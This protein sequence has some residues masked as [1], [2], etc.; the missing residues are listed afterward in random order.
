L[1]GFGIDG[2]LWRGVHERLRAF[3][4]VI[5][6][7]LPGHGRSTAYQG[8]VRYASEVVCLLDSLGV[9]RAHWVGHSI[10]GAIAVDAALT[11]PSRVASLV[12]VGSVLLRGSAPPNPEQIALATLASSGDLVGARRAW[13][14]REPFAPA[15]RRPDLCEALRAMID[16]YTGAHWLGTLRGVWQEPD[17]ASHLAAVRAPTLVAVGEDD[18]AAA[19]DAAVAY[20]EGIHGAEL[21]RL[22]G[23][24]HMLPMEDPVKTAALIAAFVD[25]RSTA[26][27]TEEK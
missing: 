3:H 1:H 24:S 26:R 10:G 14:E 23:A 8:A 13:F 15:R 11:E 27:W 18:T 6:P 21:V 12:L 2:R 16:G 17:H 19:R 22:A 20:A 5:V 4:R 9:A 7:D 25:R